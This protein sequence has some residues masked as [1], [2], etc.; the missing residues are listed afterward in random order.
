MRGLIWANKIIDIL[1]LS[2]QLKE[3]EEGLFTG[4]INIEKQISHL[5][6]KTIY[7]YVEKKI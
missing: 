6:P 1:R 3:I 7:F 5:L 4:K 2:K